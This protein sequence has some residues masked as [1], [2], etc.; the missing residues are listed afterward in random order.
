MICVRNAPHLRHRRGTRARKPHLGP[1][2]VTGTQIGA[3]NIVD[4][5]DFPPTKQREKS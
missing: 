1:T 4:D 3:T 5:N 2:A